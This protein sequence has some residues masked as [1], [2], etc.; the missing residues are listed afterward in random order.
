[1]L[2]S[3][4]RRAYFCKSIAVEMGGVVRYFSKVSGSGVDL[5]LLIIMEFHS[6]LVVEWQDTFENI[7]F[8]ALLES[9]MCPS[10]FLRAQN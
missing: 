8:S 6:S 10:V 2:L 1:M 9:G 4:T 7:L 5:T 3:A